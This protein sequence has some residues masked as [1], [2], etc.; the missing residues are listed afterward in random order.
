M[1]I[2][3]K[4]PNYTAIFIWLSVL[5]A[6]EL[7][8]ATMGI[9]KVV[10][11]SALIGLAIAKA[12]LVALYFM[13]LRFERLSLGMIALTPPILLLILTFAVYPDSLGALLDRE[14][15]EA[16]TQTAPAHH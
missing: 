11:V 5:T 2:A 15:S 1:A 4:E 16:A 8:I 10:I 7:W 14:H 12:M 9:A 3:H 6:L 13:H